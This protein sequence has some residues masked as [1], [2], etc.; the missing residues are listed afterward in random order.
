VIVRQIPPCS[1]LLDGQPMS[2]PE[3]AADHFPSPPAF[4][5]N[6]VIAVNGLPDRHG[7]RPLDGGFGCW[8]AEVGE[9]LMDRRNQSAELLGPDLIASDIRGH[10]FRSELSIG[11]CGRLLARH[12]L[13]PH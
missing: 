8:L 3:M 13:S 10:D 7:R 4:Y 5:A 9:R 6:D 1:I 2:G 12:L 11:R